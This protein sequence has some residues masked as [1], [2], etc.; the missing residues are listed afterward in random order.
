M[1]L[2]K[3]LTENLGVKLIA[4][5]VAMFVWFNA[6]GQKEVVW[7]KNIPVTLDNL[8]DSLVV[9]GNPPAH[10]EISITGT[11]RQLILTGFKRISLAIDLAGAVPGRQRVSLS[12]R[13]IQLP[14]GIE[15]HN[16]RILEPTAIDLNLERLTTRRVQVTL[17]TTGAIPEHYVVVDGAFSITPSWTYVKGA[18]AEVN[19]IETIPTEPLDLGRLKESIERDIALD[20]DRDRLECKPGVV[21]VSVRISEKGTRVLANVPPTVLVDS[22]DYD[23]KV[24]PR[25]VSLT[26][27]GAR[28]VLDTLSSGDVSVLLDLSGRGEARYK[29]APEIILP[30]GV[31]L[32]R[33]SVD[34][35]VV[36]IFKNAKQKSP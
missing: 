8:P 9:V 11:K 22:E 19:R 23:A 4:L 12:S 14:G 6:S 15:R 35:L 32:T 29:L 3:S 1:N 28:A 10:V 18:A 27:E 30:P 21:K 36:D 17:T 25:T 26:L 5:V 33:V 16:V 13:N 34:S 2:K 31:V 20:F 24:F 7:L